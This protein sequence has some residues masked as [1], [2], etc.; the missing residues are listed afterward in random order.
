MHNQ[1]SFY[2]DVSQL[3]TEEQIEEF[4]ADDEKFYKDYAKK[5]WLNKYHEL[6]KLASATQIP[7]ITSVLSDMPSIGGNNNKSKTE[8]YALKSIEAQERVDFLH[9]C[10]EEIPQE[11]KEVIEKRFLVRN[12]AGKSY[13]NDYL[14]D[15]MGV[16]RSLFYK[17]QN[18]ALYELGI[19]LFQY[20]II[21]HEQEKKMQEQKEE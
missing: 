15:I 19:C 16:S 4:L 13:N 1:L 12:S 8:E 7:S 6:K 20:E 14:A 5:N 3:F 17:M 2:G 9:E 21:Q 11:Y 18:K 10:L